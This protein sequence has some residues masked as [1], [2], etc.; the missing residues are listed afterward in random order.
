MEPAGSP[1]PPGPEPG[2][3]PGAA[4]GARLSPVPPGAPR[5]RCRC[6]PCPAARRVRGSPGGGTGCFSQRSRRGRPAPPRSL[7][8]PPRSLPVPVP[9]R[10]GSARGADAVPVLPAPS[11]GCAHPVCHPRNPRCCPWIRCPP[12]AARARCPNLPR[13]W[14]HPFPVHRGHFKAVLSGHPGCQQLFG[15]VTSRFPSGLSPHGFGRVRTRWDPRLARDGL[16]TD[17]SRERLMSARKELS[18][19]ER[20]FCAFC[21]RTE[22]LDWIHEITELLK[23]EKPSQTIRFR[24][25][26]PNPQGPL[27]HI[28]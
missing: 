26:H 12:R 2:C 17:A 11:P 28:L 16:E 10:P 3:A 9:P 25:L 7:P 8:V 13:P 6:R 20:W 23:L 5:C 27:L 22:L 14:A 21:V 24:F 19:D 18:G 15:T 1:A 4:A